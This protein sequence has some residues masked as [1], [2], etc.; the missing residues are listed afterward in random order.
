MSIHICMSTFN[1]RDQFPKARKRILDVRQELDL[2]QI[3]E[4]SRNNTFK[5]P[6]KK[7]DTDSSDGSITTSDI[8]Y[9]DDINYNSNSQESSTNKSNP[10]SMD[11]GIATR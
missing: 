8:E 7:V 10:R 2:E 11:S 1:F 9:K 5:S 6:A 4:E 3:P